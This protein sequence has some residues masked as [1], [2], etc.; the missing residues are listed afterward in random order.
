MKEFMNTM[1][2]ILRVGWSETKT[3]MLC[4]AVA[5]MLGMVIM[6]VILAAAGENEYF[7]FGA[8]MSIMIGMMLI[9][10]GGTLSFQ[11]DFNMAISLGKTR[12]QYVPAKFCIILMNCAL[13]MVIT[14]LIG[15]LEESLYKGMYPQARELLGMGT[16][17]KYPG[18]IVGIVFLAAVVILLVGALLLKFGMKIFWV[19][20]V[21]WMISNTL[22]PRIITATEEAPDSFWGRVGGMVAGFFGRFSE[23]QII[24]TL[25]ISGLVGVIIA[26]LL[27]RKQRV[28]A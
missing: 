7:I 21:L 17:L 20:W 25:L 3:Y 8:L 27:L 16:I 14:L 24:I 5:G 1:K 11:A 2:Q 13:C 6:F 9:F 12:K 10:F 4:S 18:Y 23:A 19:I 26:F 28:T 15:S 22:I